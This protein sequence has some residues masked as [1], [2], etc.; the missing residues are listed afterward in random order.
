MAPAG[1]HPHTARV[2][3]LVILAVGLRPKDLA[4]APV[5]RGLG[6]HGF[7]AP[8]DTVFPAVTCTVQASFLTGLQPRDHG[9]VGNGWY[10]RELA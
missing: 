5:L 3:L 4:H 10:F 6:A 7:A 8:L 1:R 2:K 9:A